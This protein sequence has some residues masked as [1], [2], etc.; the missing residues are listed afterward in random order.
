MKAIDT[1]LYSLLNADCGTVMGTVTGSLKNLG[2]T[3]VYRAVA[4]Q[5]ATLPFVVFQQ[6]S[7]VSEWEFR[8]RA[9]KTTTY[10]VKAVGTGHSASNVSAM[11]DRLDTLLNDAN[12]SLSG[13]SCRRIRREQDIEYS[14]ESEGVLYQHVGGLYRIDVE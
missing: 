12:L 13:W 2:A 1:G 3:G 7:G 8:T 9:Y 6:Q 10:L 14:E 11:A 4:P 5:T